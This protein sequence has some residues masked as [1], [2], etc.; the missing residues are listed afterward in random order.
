MAAQIIP[1]PGAATAHIVQSRKR[2]RLPKV[3][4]SMRAYRRKRFFASLDAST[5]ADEIKSRRKTIAFFE[6]SLIEQRCELAVLSRME[7]GAA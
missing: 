2:G 5:R 7:G 1:L 6:Q 4:T 3:V